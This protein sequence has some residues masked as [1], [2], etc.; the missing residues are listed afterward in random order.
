[1]HENKRRRH[2]AQ[3]KTDWN[4]WVLKEKMFRNP[5]NIRSDLAEL[6]RA[7]EESNT[8]SGVEMEVQVV[9]ENMMTSMKKM[10]MILKAGTGWSSYFGLSGL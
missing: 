7:S 1:M 9:V 3:I 4:D 10:T 8:V 5:Y 6:K 2:R